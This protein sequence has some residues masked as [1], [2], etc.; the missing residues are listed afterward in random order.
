MP[1]VPKTYQPSRTPA[2]LEMR[3]NLVLILG[4]MD[5]LELFQA[6]AHLA[7]SIHCLER[8]AGLP[9]FQEAAATVPALTQGCEKGL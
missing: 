7:M 9:P 5:T 3:S 6:G 2:I 8:D 1:E 4:R